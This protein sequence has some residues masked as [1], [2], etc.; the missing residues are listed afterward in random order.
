MAAV[1]EVVTILERLPITKEAL[2]VKFRLLSHHKSFFALATFQR[3][4]IFSWFVLAKWMKI[5]PRFSEAHACERIL[6][7]VHLFSST[8]AYFNHH[9][10]GF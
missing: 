7:L 8:I 1:L 6:A 9:K 3:L 10:C 5:S 2:E 4:G